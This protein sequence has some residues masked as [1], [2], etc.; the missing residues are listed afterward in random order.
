MTL[1][2]QVIEISGVEAYQRSPFAAIAM[3]GL[4]DLVESRHAPVA[5]AVRG[6]SEQVKPGRTVMLIDDAD[7][8]DEAS[9]GAL[10]A[11]SSKLGVPVLF[12]RSVHCAEPF[13]GFRPANGFTFVYSLA[14][15]AMSYAELETTLEHHLEAKIEA[16]T[17]SRVYA[18]SAGNIGTALSIVDAGKRGGNILLEHGTLRATGELWSTSLS[19][20][21]R[22]ILQPLSG[23][24]IRA[25]R[26]LAL[27]GT[28]ELDTASRL[29]PERQIF[30]LEEKSY[31]TLFDQSERRHL[32]LQPPLLAE[33]FRHESTPVS[34]PRY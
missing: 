17:L 18:K 2:W 34:G 1:G 21:A 22:I 25:L 14:L 20:L 28:A 26:A 11:V 4:T 9:W 32:A 12:T 15:P 3:T 31:I 30:A 16:S 5:A 8:V 6:L 33:Y 29:V 23:K 10:S 7:W 24:D 19:A 27:L 13:R